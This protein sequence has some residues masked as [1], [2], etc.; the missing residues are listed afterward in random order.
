MIPTREEIDA[1]IKLLE[2]YAPRILSHSAFGECHTDAIEAQ[3]EV[4]KRRLVEDDIE[5]EYEDV[6]SNVRENAEYAARWLE[7]DVEDGKPSDGWVSLLDKEP[8]AQ[9]QPPGR[10]DPPGRFPRPEEKEA[11]TSPTATKTRKIQAKTPKNNK[12]A[13]RK[14]ASR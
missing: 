8:V 5:E 2:S 4:L 7:D 3:I 13:G 12:K 9:I 10:L 1:E 11:V 6:A 14:K